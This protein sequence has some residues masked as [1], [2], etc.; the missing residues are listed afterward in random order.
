VKWFYD[1][2]VKLATDPSKNIPAEFVI[3]MANFADVRDVARAHMEVLRQDK[4][5]GERYIIARR[6][7]VLFL[8]SFLYRC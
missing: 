7:F 1:E 6:E 4:A 3:P 2:I 5:G 8:S